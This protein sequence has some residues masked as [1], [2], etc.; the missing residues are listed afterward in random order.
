MTNSN[1]I[2]ASHTEPLWVKLRPK[3]WK[4]FVDYCALR[5]I[6]ERFDTKPF[7]FLIY[8]P[9]GCGKTTFIEILLKETRINHAIVPAASTSLEEIRKI[10]KNAP[11]I[12]FMDEFHRFSK[13]R[14]DYFLKP[15]EDGSIILIAATTESPWYYIT[16]PLLS[17][18]TIK[19]MSLPEKSIFENIIRDKWKNAGFELFSDNVITEVIESTWPD[20]RKAYQSLEYLYPLQTVQKLSEEEIISAL[21]VY[22]RENKTLG[23]DVKSEQY[24][25]LSAMIK[26]VRGSDPDA[27]L[28]YMASL[29]NLGADPV[30][31]ARRL[32]ILASE[33]VGLANS[34]GL[35]V[36]SQGLS[37]IEK[38]GMPEAKII[39]SHILIYLSLLPKSNSAYRAVKK[40][41]TFAAEHNFSVPGYLLNHHKETKN[42]KYPHD[43][44]G[45][46]NQNYWPANLLKEKLYDP[47]DTVFDISLENKLIENQKKIKE[48]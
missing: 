46:V 32:V 28:L 3:K 1:N 14:Q 16:R 45:Y 43:Y 21:E 39:L 10:A 47:N 2:F 40:A 12:I 18:F 38:I 42:Y 9:P 41:E 15:I 30:L 11:V 4:D 24:D 6:K 33:D 27:A 22:L 23:A 26:S 19:E 44:K 31:I 37:A 8:G 17:R 20:F 48:Q 7:S 25:L 35:V 36:A 5:D 13:A 29:L 34:Q